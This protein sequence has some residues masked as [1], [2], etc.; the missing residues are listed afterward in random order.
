MIHGWISGCENDVISFP[1]HNHL[2]GLHLE[3]K[4]I[5]P[6]A[7]TVPTMWHKLESSP[8]PH[9]LFGYEE[10]S[11]AFFSLLGAKKLKTKI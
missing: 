9:I 11:K 7:L 10:L 5:T 3:G 1:L 8:I 2:F 6:P 4:I